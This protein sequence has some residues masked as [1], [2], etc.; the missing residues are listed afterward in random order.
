MAKDLHPDKNPDNEAIAERFKEV[1][2]AYSILGDKDRRAKFDRGEIDSSGAERNPFAGAGGGGFAGGAGFEDAFG[3]GGFGGRA[4]GPGGDDLFSELFGFGRGRAQQNRGPQ[5]GQDVTYQVTVGFMDAAKGA[6]RRVTLE[7]GK[8]LDVKIPA[9]VQTGQQIKL[10]GQGR[11]GQKSGPSGNA[12]VKI[13]VADH[14]FFTRDGLNINLDLPITI[15]EAVMGATV[16]VPTIAGKVS[17]KVPKNSSSGRRLRLKGKGI[18]KERSP[19][20]RW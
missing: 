7:G 13:T 5:K 8:E 18:Q 1:S 3:R 16:S 6:V 10:S 17:L 9:G 2:A 14:P 19:A 4:T 12:L 11:P 15:D 20:T